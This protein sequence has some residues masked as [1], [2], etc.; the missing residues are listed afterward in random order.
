MNY[1]D[2]WMIAIFINSAL[3]SRHSFFGRDLRFDLTFVIFTIYILTTW[4]Y[5]LLK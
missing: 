3:T 4:Y 5:N 1:S 2:N